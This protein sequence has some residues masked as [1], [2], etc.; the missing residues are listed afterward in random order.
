MNN[1][2]LSMGGKAFC[3]LFFMGSLLSVSPIQANNSLRQPLAITQQ[4]QIQGTVTDG[5]NPLAGVSISIQ[6]K[7]NTATITDYNGHYTLSA[8]PAAILVFTYVG[9]YYHQH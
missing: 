4:H 7:S 1:F 9:A 8:A 3:F 2:S 6:G 5:G